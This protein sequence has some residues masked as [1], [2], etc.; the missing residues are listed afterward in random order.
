MLL[1]SLERSETRPGI[2][3]L[4]DGFVTMNPFPMDGVA[5]LL[6]KQAPIYDLYYSGRD[7]DSIAAFE[8]RVVRPMTENKTMVEVAGI[9]SLGDKA[10]EALNQKGYLVTNMYEVYPDFMKY[11]EPLFLLQIRYMDTAR[12]LIKYTEAYIREENPVESRND[13][14]FRSQ[15]SL[16]T[17]VREAPFAFN[18]PSLPKDYELVINDRKY[19]STDGFKAGKIFVSEGDSLRFHKSNTVPYL[20]MIQEISKRTPIGSKP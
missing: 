9:Q 15:D 18:W 16:V 19:T 4:I 14:R 6:N 2:L 13:L 17:I 5:K 1:R 10:V 3:Q 20:I 12:Y 7:P 11:E 8:T